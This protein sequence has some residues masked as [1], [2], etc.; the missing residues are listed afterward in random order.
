MRIRNESK[1]PFR[2]FIALTRFA[3]IRARVGAADTFVHATDGDVSVVTA[4]VHL[5]GGNARGVPERHYVDVAIPPVQSELWDEE[6]VRAMALAF[7][8][9]EGVAEAERQAEDVVVSYRG[10]RS[11][12]TPIFP[13]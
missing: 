8:R 4:T 9:I 11:V 7:A 1:S 13:K 10:K 12:F 2:A 6:I 3:A 5:D